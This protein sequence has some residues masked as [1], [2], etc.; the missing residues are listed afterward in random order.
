[1]TDT[2]DVSDFSTTLITTAKI[3]SGSV[4]KEIMDDKA[5][6]NQL[7]CSLI[8]EG[9]TF[10]IKGN[11]TKLYSWQSSVAA[12]GVHKWLAVDVNTGESTITSVTYNGSALTSDDV[13][14]ATAWGLPA[15]HFILWLKCDEIA[16]TP[17]TITLGASGKSPETL[18]FVFEGN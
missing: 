17:K 8:R 9:N 3:I 12:Q 18:V 14:D 1:M 16:L 5:E 2:L 11:L 7:A 13:A 4:A 10:K 15:G 6:Y